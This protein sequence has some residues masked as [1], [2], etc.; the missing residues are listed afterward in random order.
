LEPSSSDHQTAS[1]E[2]NPHP[3]FQGLFAQTLETQPQH[4]FD[5]VDTLIDSYT[6]LG[7][8]LL[9]LI[10][11]ICVNAV[12]VRKIMKKYMKVVS[13]FNN[14]K[15]AHRPKGI[16]EIDKDDM[17][18]LSI[19]TYEAH[20]HQLASS[21]SMAAIHSSLSARLE[22]FQQHSRQSAEVDPTSILRL[23]GVIYCLNELLKYSKVVN[24][25]Y[26]AFLSRKAMIV[27]GDVGLGDLDAP[28][29]QALQVMLKFNPDALLEMDEGALGTW[30]RNA[31]TLRY[32]SK[33][34]SFDSFMVMSTDSSVFPEERDNF[35]GGIDR[36]SMILNLTSTLLYTVRFHVL[37]MT[38]YCISTCSHFFISY[39]R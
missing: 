20:L 9:H 18:Y 1:Q 26:D 36:T 22:E 31:A 37:L 39:C 7:V 2:W 12:G 13:E 16:S 4:V 28:T 6:Y 24:Q 30:E 38:C 19:E 23:K 27:T 5:D 29:I 32:R 10:R 34:Y 33:S 17:D 3:L 8:E 35:W 11:F 14:W 21:Q 15:L 25:P